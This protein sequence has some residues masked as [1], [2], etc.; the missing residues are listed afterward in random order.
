MFTPNLYR[1]ITQSYAIRTKNKPSMTL[2]FS[3]DRWCIAPLFITWLTG[4]D[5]QMIALFNLFHHHI[6]TGVIH[7]GQTQ[8]SFTQ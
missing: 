8:Q 7:T 2:G 3:L 1:D 6:R 5:N 4:M